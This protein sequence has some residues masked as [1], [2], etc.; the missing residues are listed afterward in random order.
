[1]KQSYEKIVRLR[2]FVFPYTKHPLSIFT[3]LIDN[4]LSACLIIK[5][6][7]VLYGVL[8]VGDP[9]ASTAVLFTNTVNKLVGNAVQRTAIYKVA[10]FKT[11][12]ST[13]VRCFK[14]LRH[15][16]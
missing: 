14:T 2:F 13:P 1:M 12:T 9:L 16:A 7:W 8:G 15:L 11:L 3:F 5:R 4:R 6:L 10:G